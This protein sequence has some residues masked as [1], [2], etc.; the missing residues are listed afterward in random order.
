MHLIKTLFNLTRNRL[1]SIYIYK[2]LSQLLGL[3]TSGIAI[4]VCFPGNVARNEKIREISKYNL[5]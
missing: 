4:S 2:T 1:A 3:S 5:D